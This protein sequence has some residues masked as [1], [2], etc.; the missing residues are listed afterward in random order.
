MTNY[1]SHNNASSLTSITAGVS[2]DCFFSDRWSIKTKFSSDN[3]GWSD[4][5]YSLPQSKLITGD[6]QLSYITIPVMANWHFGVKR[7]WYLNFR[8][9]AGILLS[10]KDSEFNNDLKEDF[11][12]T[13]FGVALG[14][15]FKFVINDRTKFYIEY[16]GQAGI[17]SLFDENIGNDARNRRSSVIL[18]FFLNFRLKHN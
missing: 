15:G 8:L 11:N 10:A 5:Y 3:K 13:D 9:Y 14:I 1:N 16:D 2:G 7:S 6:F 17:F 4:E 18:V 12:S